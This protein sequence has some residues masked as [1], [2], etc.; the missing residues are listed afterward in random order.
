MNAKRTIV[1]KINISF[2]VKRNMMMHNIKRRFRGAST[3]EKF[4]GVSGMNTKRTIFK[5]IDISFIIYFCLGKKSFCLD[6]F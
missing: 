2:I 6:T 5:K 4:A 3:N 1:K